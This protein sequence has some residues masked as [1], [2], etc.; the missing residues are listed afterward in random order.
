MITDKELQELFSTMET[1]SAKVYCASE[2]NFLKTLDA[3]LEKVEYIKQMQD[4]Q[5]K[6]YK[7]AIYHALMTG[8]VVGALSMAILYHAGQWL[9]KLPDLG[10]SLNA[11]VV[12]STILAFIIGS[13]AFWLTRNLQEIKQMVSE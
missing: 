1:Q 11:R 9:P 4:N 12:I 5:N 13:C 2:D 7:R 6:K 3:R 10:L 8:V